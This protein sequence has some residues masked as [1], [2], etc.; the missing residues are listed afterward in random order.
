MNETTHCLAGTNYKF[1]IYSVTLARWYKVWYGVYTCVCEGSFWTQEQQK[2]S[3]VHYWGMSNNEHGNGLGH[4]STSSAFRLG[5]SCVF[6]NYQKFLHKRRLINETLLTLIMTAVLK[7]SLSTEVFRF[8]LVIS[9]VVL[10][11]KTMF[12][13]SF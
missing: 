12:S 13:N 9:V 6:T 1:I 4:H 10:V 3:N 2:L 11:Y 5:N 8:L 7:K